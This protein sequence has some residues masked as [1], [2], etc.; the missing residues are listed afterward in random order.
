MSERSKSKIPSNRKAN[1][2]NIIDENKEAEVKK[3][4]GRRTNSIR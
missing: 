4:V 3:Q 2:L 1:L